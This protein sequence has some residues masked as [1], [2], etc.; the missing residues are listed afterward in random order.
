MD[1]ILAVFFVIFID[2]RTDHTFLIIV[3]FYT[4]TVDFATAQLINSNATTDIALRNDG[5]ATVTTIAR[6]DLTNAIAQ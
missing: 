6:T 4:Q 5:Y 1:L 2:C 3:F